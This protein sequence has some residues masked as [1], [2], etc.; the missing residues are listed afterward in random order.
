MDMNEEARAVP[1]DPPCETCGKPYSAA[2][3]IDDCPCCTTVE[4]DGIAYH[5][6]KARA[7][8]VDGEPREN[9]RKVPGPDSMD[10]DACACPCQCSDCWC[11]DSP[12]GRCVDCACWP[13]DGESRPLTDDEAL[14]AAEADFLGGRFTTDPPVG[15]P[16]PRCET[17]LPRS[18]SPEAWIHTQQAIDAGEG[19]PFAPPVDIPRPRVWQADYALRRIREADL[20]TDLFEP[21]DDDPDEV[22]EVLRVA[23]ACLGT[24]LADWPELPPVG[25]PRPLCETCGQPETADCVCGMPGMVHHWHEPKDRPSAP[26]CLGRHLF[27]P[28]VGE[29]RSGSRVAVTR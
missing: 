2:V 24:Y 12:D 19:H 25:E 8:P 28:H 27:V 16:R 21:Q 1:V 18:H 23:K 13:V 10:E 7:V 5:P 17:C 14:E 15:E 29:P 4:E 9:A 11:G 26:G 6:F 20:A 22:R 3:V